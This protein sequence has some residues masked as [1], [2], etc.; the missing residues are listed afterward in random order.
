MSVGDSLATELEKLPAVVR[1]SSLAEAAKALAETIDGAP[2]A[3]DL[4]AAVK[5]F[6]A[7]MADLKVMAGQAPE[8][9]DPID[10]LEQS[11]PGGQPG[12][13][14]SYLPRRSG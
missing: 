4:A 5:E 1:E 12:A 3:R 9:R 8:E 7:T 6:R 13:T 2:G 10:Q 11:G 14:V